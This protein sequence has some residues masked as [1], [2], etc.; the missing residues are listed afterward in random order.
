MHCVSCVYIVCVSTYA[1]YR[2]D[3]EEHLLGLPTSF[4]LAANSKSVGDEGRLDAANNKH[5]CIIHLQECS[6]VGIWELTGCKELSSKS[7]ERTRA[8]GSSLSP[9]AVC[10]ATLSAHVGSVRHIPGAASWVI[11]G[12]FHFSGTGLESSQDTMPVQHLI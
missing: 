2:N 10:F 9:C 5:F 12:D 4:C 11:L 1:P 8:C 6:T 7:T 3:T